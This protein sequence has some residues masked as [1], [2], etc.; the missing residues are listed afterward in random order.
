[1]IFRKRAFL[2][3]FSRI[4]GNNYTLNLIDLDRHETKIKVLA[5]SLLGT[6]I[7]SGLLPF[8]SIINLAEIKI[9]INILY[10]CAREQYWML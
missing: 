2:H 1:M 7:H 10:K 4:T 3:E 5:L 8:L 6:L 9:S